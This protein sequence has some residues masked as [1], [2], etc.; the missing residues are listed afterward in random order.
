MDNQTLSTILWI[1][2]IVVLVLYFMR[3]RSRRSKSFK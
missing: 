3:R 2:A 1:A